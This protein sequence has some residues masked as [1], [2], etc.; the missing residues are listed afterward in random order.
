MKEKKREGQN[1]AEAFEA[2][3]QSPEST[4]PVLRIAITLRR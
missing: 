3:K 2:L 4:E 1:Q